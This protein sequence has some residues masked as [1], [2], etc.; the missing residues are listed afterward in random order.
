MPTIDEK[1]VYAEQSGA[2]SVHVASE[3]GHVVADVSGDIVG[4][5]RL[6]ERCV[7]RDVAVAD[8]VLAL[9]TDADVLVGRDHEPANLGPA[10]A[11]SVH[12]G[13]VLAALEGGAIVR[14]EP[15]A[16]EWEELGTVE[17]PRAVDGPLVAAADGVHRVVDGDLRP[18]G[19]TEVRDVAGAGVPL[20]ATADGLYYLANGW[21]DARAG[22]HEVVD[23]DG[24]SAH[25]VDAEGTVLAGALETWE[26]VAVPTDERVVGATYAEGLTVLA[27]E[28][29]TLLTNAGEGWRGRSVGVTGVGGVDAP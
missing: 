19:L 3:Q 4:E 23:G 24:D 16:D 6:V 8:G 11:V 18:A 27:T 17:D 9:A 20:A 28:R 21:M 26:P 25:A 10:V 1:R 2:V 12:E 5:F 14:R 15:D 22:A 29:G 7:A 13:A